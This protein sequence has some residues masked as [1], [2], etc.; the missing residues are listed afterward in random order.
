MGLGVSA[1]HSVWRLAFSTK[2][3]KYLCCLLPPRYSSEVLKY[4]YQIKCRTTKIYGLRI[5]LEFFEPK[6]SWPTAHL[7]NTAHP[8]LMAVEKRFSWKSHTQVCSKPWPIWLQCV[9]VRHGTYF[10]EDDNERQRCGGI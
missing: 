9:A 3:P 5:V 7:P 2:S 4:N 8:L 10:I 6:Q 1:L